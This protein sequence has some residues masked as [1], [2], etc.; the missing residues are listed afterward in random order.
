[1]ILQLLVRGAWERRV[2]GDAVRVGS[3]SLLAVEAS[4]VELGE[5]GLGDDAEQ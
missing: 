4:L 5:D 3:L 2:A 1:M